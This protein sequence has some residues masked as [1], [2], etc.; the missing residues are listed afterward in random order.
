M[1]Q[2]ATDTSTA[3]SA[4]TVAVPI[5]RAWEVWTTG[6]S[7]WWPA[8]HHIASE[9]FEDAVLEPRAGGRWYD[10][11]ASG[12]EC[13][14]GVVRAWEPPTRLVVTWQIGSDWKFDPDP[15]HASEV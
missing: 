3:R 2:Q 5:E 7:S 9:P 10:R 15:A 1:N 11:P 12:A 13:D 6:M 8:G 4:I 14:W